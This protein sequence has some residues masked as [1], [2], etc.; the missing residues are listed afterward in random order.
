MLQMDES[1]PEH[2]PNHWAVYFAVN[3]CDA[4]V[5]KAEAF[6]ASVLMSPTEV[7]PGRFA[8][9]K[10]P[11]G[12]IFSVIALHQQEPDAESRPKSAAELD[13]ELDPDQHPT[14][15]AD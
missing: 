3:D 9:I 8:T 10:D 2:V 14:F 13:P 11:Q 6:G 5:A 15:E 4:A 7:L 12:A 1:W